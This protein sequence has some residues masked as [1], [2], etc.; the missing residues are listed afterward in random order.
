MDTVVRMRRVYEVG[1]QYVAAHTHDC[2]AIIMRVFCCSMFAVS[3][4]VLTRLGCYLLKPLH[5]LTPSL[6]SPQRTSLPQ[7]TSFCS[8]VS[9]ETVEVVLRTGIPRHT[10]PSLFYRNYNP[11]SLPH[12]LPLSFRKEELY[13]YCCP[14]DSCILYCSTRFFGPVI[15]N[16]DRQVYWSSIRHTARR[17]WRPKTAGATVYDEGGATA[18]LKLPN[19]INFSH[20][21]SKCRNWLFLFYSA[22]LISSVPTVWYRRSLFS[23]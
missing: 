16:D 8:L 3:L 23:F 18:R 22:V 12:Y 11:S 15:R 5:L 21:S 4:V 7:R 14:V 10:P 19:Y 20:S 6:S 9:V 13:K 2:F 1:T 17:T